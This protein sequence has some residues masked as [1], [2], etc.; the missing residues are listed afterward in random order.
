M[1]KARYTVYD[2][3]CIPIKERDVAHVEQLNPTVCPTNSTIL[4]SHNTALNKNNIGEKEA[5]M[6]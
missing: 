1:E 2:T 5:M 3:D 6:K 4:V